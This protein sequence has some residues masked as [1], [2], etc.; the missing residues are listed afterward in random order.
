MTRKATTPAADGGF[1]GGIAG[2][3]GPASSLSTRWLGWAGEGREDDGGTGLPFGYYLDLDAL[4]VARSAAQCGAQCSALFYAEAWIEGRFGEAAGVAA[5]RWREQGEGSAGDGL[6]G[7]GD[8]HHFDLIAG[9]GAGEGEAPVA[10][11]SW[12]GHRSK[13]VR[14]VNEGGKRAPSS[15]PALPPAPPSGV[16]KRE[17]EWLLLEVFSSLPEP[18]SI[19][20]VPAPVADLSAQAAVYAHEGGWQS[21]L[22]AYDTLLQQQQVLAG[23]AFTGG[24]SGVVSGSLFTA[25]GGVGW[26]MAG[27]GLQIGIAT[28]LQVRFKKMGCF[29]LR[30]LFFVSL[31]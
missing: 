24:G 19:Y 6:D 16:E 2:E 31:W 8:D 30:V 25:E 17:V 14:W 7:G 1:N 4:Q 23:R 15:P 21:T 26:P 12:D 11:P 28:S 22:P 29:F 27:A 9:G 18:D 5:S 13:A 10:V 20:G 3:A